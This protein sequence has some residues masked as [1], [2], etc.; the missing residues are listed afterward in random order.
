MTLVQCLR[1]VTI[2][3]CSLQ[4]STWEFIQKV[5]VEFERFL[6]KG[7]AWS[8]KAGSAR[9]SEKYGAGYELILGGQDQLVPQK[10]GQ[11]TSWSQEVGSTRAT[12]SCLDA[13]QIV[14]ED[15]Q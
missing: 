15:P 8:Q 10:M 4:W 14:P 11:G 5:Y 13:D 12:K 9:T 6:G 3:L 2:E 7:T 1:K